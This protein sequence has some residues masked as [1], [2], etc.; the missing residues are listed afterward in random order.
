MEVQE[1]IDAPRFSTWSF[2]NS[3]AP[4][5][6][7]PNRVMI[8]D[9]FPAP[10]IDELAARGHEVHRWPQFTRDAAAV[11]AIHLDASSGFLSAGADSRQ[12]A[13]AIVS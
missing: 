3:F 8:E 5:Q 4:F 13:Y 12:P 11:E 2:P 1:A 9:R 7:L 10:L 6:Y